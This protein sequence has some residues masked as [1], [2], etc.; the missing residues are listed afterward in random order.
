MQAKDIK[1]LV[2]KQ[3]KQRIPNWRR[4]PRKQK[5][6]LAKEVLAEV[7]VGSLPADWKLV[8]MSEL[9]GTPWS[10]GGIISLNKMGTFVENKT[11]GIMSLSKVQTPKHLKGDV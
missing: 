6:A 10:L 5:K 1:R 2:R 3:L 4:L 9:T 8:P 11:R 7:A